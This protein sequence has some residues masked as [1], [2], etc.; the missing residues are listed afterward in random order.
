MVELWRNPS[1]EVTLNTV[2]NSSAKA[3]S[4]QD[5]NLSA[6]DAAKIAELRNTIA[7]LKKEIGEVKKKN[8]MT[9]RGDLCECCPAD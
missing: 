6:E 2:P 3:A 9:Y 7:S 8:Y 1:G 5:S 4:S